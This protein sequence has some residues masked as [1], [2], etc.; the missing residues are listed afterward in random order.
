MGNN[1]MEIAKRGFGLRFGLKWQNSLCTLIVLCAI[2]FSRVCFF[3]P[4]PRPARSAA[5]ERTV[6]YSCPNPSVSSMAK[7]SFSFNCSKLLYGGRSRRLK[8]VWLRGSQVS[9]PTFSMQNFWGP[10]LPM[11]SAKPPRGS[12]QVPVT[13]CSSRKRTSLST[14]F[15]N[16]ANK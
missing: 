2:F 7:S 14:S 9:L 8:H 1:V 12:L 15:T 16:C 13:N 3:S 11:S 6:L 4:S 10:L 5:A